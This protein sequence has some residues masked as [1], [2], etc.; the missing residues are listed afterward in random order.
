MMLQYSE[1][2]IIQTFQALPAQLQT[3]VWDFMQ[4]LVFKSD[5]KNSAYIEKV[6]TTLYSK[7]NGT[8][9]T[10]IKKPTIELGLLKGKITVPEN[11][12]EPL[13]DFVEYM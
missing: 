7:K 9:D 8:D 5:E 6:T 11:F 10:I 13:P 1:N 4:F 12:N 3:E 2:Q